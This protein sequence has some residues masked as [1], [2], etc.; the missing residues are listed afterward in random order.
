[1]MTVE[2]GGEDAVLDLAR[3][4]DS[5]MTEDL[6][7]FVDGYSDWIEGQRRIGTE[8]PTPGEQDY[9]E[10]DLR[11]DERRPRAHAGVRRDAPHR[12]A[13]GRVVP[14]REPGDARPDA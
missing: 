7:R 13:R 11:P 3:L 10:P 5:P 12:S 4:A 9:R 6:A 14:A 2:T 1:M 8:L